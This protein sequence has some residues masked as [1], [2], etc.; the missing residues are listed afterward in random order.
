MNDVHYYLSDWKM[1][2]MKQNDWY[3]CAGANFFAL[4]GRYRLPFNEGEYMVRGD[5]TIDMNTRGTGLWY[6]HPLVRLGNVTAEINFGWYSLCRS[7]GH[8]SD[9]SIIKYAAT[10]AE[11]MNSI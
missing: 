8:P 5:G 9:F 4:P 7:E 6:S 1:T 3:T 11:T 2:N 10:G